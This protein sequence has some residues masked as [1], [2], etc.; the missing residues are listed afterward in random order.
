MIPIFANGIWTDLLSGWAPT[1]NN[2]RLQVTIGS[3]WGHVFCR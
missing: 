1:V 2:F 3:N